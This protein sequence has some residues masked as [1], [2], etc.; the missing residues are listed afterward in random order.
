MTRRPSSAFLGVP[1]ASIF[2]VGPA[3]QM[4]G[5]QRLTG[6]GRAILREAKS[7]H[8]TGPAPRR[9]RYVASRSSAALEDARHALVADLEA[10]RG[11]LWQGARG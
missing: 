10:L 4:L 6:L 3:R 11:R 7:Y 9:G 2:R 8:S 1:W 5:R